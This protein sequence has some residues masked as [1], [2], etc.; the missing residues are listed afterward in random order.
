[1]VPFFLLGITALA[2]GPMIPWL[3]FYWDD[4][5][6]LWLYHLQG[7]AGFPAFVASDRPFSAWIFMLETALFGETPLGY[8]LLALGLRWLSAVLFWWVL[9]LVWPRREL[10]ALW[11]ALLFAIYPGFLQQPVALIYNH[12]LSVLCLFLFSL[13]AMLLAVRK[14]GWAVLM[15][16]LGIVGALG[17][18]SIE[19]FVGLEMLRPVL[20]WLV[21]GELSLDRRQRLRKTLLHWLPYL[22][23]LALFLIWRV[24]IFKFPSYQPLL[25][26]QLHSNPLLLAAQLIWRIIS[27]IFIVTI[28]AWTN[29]AQLPAG[30]FSTAVYVSLVLASLLLAGIFLIFFKPPAERWDENSQQPSRSNRQALKVGLLALFFAGWPVWVTTLPVR[31]VFSY[32]RLTMAFIPGVSLV[33]AVFLAALERWPKIQMLLILGLVSLSVGFHFQNANTFRR[34]WEQLRTF[35]WQ[36]TWRMPGLKPGTIVFTENLPFTYYSDNSLTAPLNWTYAPDLQG[37]QLPYVFYFGDSRL[38]TRLSSLTP[39]LPV[40]QPYRSLFFQGSS[41]NLIAVYYQPPGCVYVLDGKYMAGYPSL[42][43]SLSKAQSLS[44]LGQIEALIQ[45]PAHP[46]HPLAAAKPNETW[47]YTFEKASLAWQVGDWQQIANL[48]DQAQNNSDHPNDLAEYLPFVEAFARLKLWKQAVQLTERIQAGPGY[49]RMICNTWSR[50]DQEMSL[51][52]AEQLQ[53]GQVLT[54]NHCSE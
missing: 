32:D 51:D 13:G 11:A 19:Y 2:Y 50:L 21:L 29:L 45:P 33:L 17:M 1:M 36:L 54:E 31:P 8:H 52:D 24:W 42:P 48:W 49:Q 38:G 16:L 7:P 44:N 39:G 43:E 27:D 47:C 14:P 6:Y 26:D 15:T 18:F 34:E 53:V 35:F 46:P 28:S 20:L 22:A 37:S 41:S 30:A 23:V 4:W 5:P 10:L 40:E 3:G 25:L 9:C 12:H